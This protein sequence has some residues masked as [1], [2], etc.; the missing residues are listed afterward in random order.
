MSRETA[1]LKFTA[2]EWTIQV[3]GERPYSN[4]GTYTYSENTVVLSYDNETVTGTIDGN[5]MT[6]DKKDVYIK[7]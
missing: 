4:G 2:S 7:Q 6:L 1:T 5:T 3:I